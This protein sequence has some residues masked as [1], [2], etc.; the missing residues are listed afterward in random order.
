MCC[1]PA[2][3]RALRPHR[4]SRWLI[5]AGVITTT[6]IAGSRPSELLGQT[7]S[8]RDSSGIRI[9]AN[10]APLTERVLYRISET[11]LVDIGGLSDD[12]QAELAAVASAVRLAN[13][14]LVITQYSSQPKVSEL[15]V[16]DPRGRYV[17]TIGRI[18]DGPGEFREIK[19]VFRIGGDSLLTYDGAGRVNYFDSAGRFA[20][21]E[22]FTR[23]LVGRFT[24]GSFL[25]SASYATPSRPRTPSE[26]AFGARDSIRLFHASASAVI[27]SGRPFP[28]GARDVV[29]G[30]RVLIPYSS[31]P[32]IAVDFDRFC[33]AQGGAF[34][35]SVH[36]PNGKP[37]ALIHVSLAPVKIKEADVARELELLLKNKPPQ[38]VAI[39]REKY[40]KHA[41]D[42]P[43][44][45]SLVVDASHR[46]WA[47]TS[48]RFG[49]STMRWFVFAPDG[50]LQGSVTLLAKLRVLEIG[51]DYLLG[52]IMD[53]D[54][55]LRVRVYSLIA[56]RARE[57]P[58]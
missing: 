1:D 9:V 47:S 44:F 41:A 31:L 30:V 26:A 37:T 56:P 53:S 45:S 22:T 7:A 34:T 27:D 49:E 23:P 24:D 25:V 43:A 36:A 42:Y 18:G 17:R 10:P 2:T 51:T 29:S 39:N 13:G 48:A 32:A 5:V 6:I 19:R 21:P 3:Q 38:V 55:A 33:F 40:A 50:R 8:V 20:R 4:I 35:I 46:L 12:P 58:R 57:V 15:R 54:D 16:F 11:P 14:N 52:T 28:D